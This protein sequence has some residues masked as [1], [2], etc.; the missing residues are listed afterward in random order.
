VHFGVI[1]ACSQFDTQFN[2]IPHPP[3]SVTLHPSPLTTLQNYCNLHLYKIFFLAFVLAFFSCCSNC[4]KA[5]RPTYEF[6]NFPFASSGQLRVCPSSTGWRC[7]GISTTATATATARAK[8]TATRPERQTA[9]RHA[10]GFYRGRV[11]PP[12][13]APFSTVSSGCHSVPFRPLVTSVRC[14]AKMKNNPKFNC[15]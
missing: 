7:H 14:A 2:P 9:L 4:T 13:H 15:K 10:S 6:Y 3:H 12:L 5:T 8:A 1:F 11:N